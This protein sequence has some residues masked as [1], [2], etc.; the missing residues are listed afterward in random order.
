MTFERE[1]SQ[2]RKNDNMMQHSYFSPWKGV[3]LSQ[4]GF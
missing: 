3:R 1:R 2:I 4:A